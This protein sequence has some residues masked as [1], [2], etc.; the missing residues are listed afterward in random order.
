[1]GVRTL[2]VF[3]VLLGKSALEFCTSLKEGLG[4]H[5]RSYETLSR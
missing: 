3:H 2:T 1:M 5:V 4:T